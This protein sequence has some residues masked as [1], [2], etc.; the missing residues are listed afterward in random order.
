MLRIFAWNLDANV[1]ALKVALHHLSEGDAVPTITVLTEVPD[2]IN[3]QNHGGNRRM[4]TDYFRRWLAGYMKGAAVTSRWS[5]QAVVRMTSQ[6]VA[7]TRRGHNQSHTAILYAGPRELKFRHA[8]ERSVRAEIPG[9]YPVHVVGLHARSSRDAKERQ[10]STAPFA[11]ASA[12]RKVLEKQRGLRIIAGDFNEQPFDPVLMDA[13]GYYSR[14]TKPRHS[15]VPRCWANLTWQAI[16]WN[17]IGTWWDNKAKTWKWFDQI[18]VDTETAE[19]V[20][21]VRVLETVGNQASFS[22][23]DHAP[24]E[25]ILRVEMEL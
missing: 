17:S 22:L 25:A 18:L 10:E 21:S 24:I 9:F 5:W 11:S 13:G 12:V 8:V 3:L 4:T 6:A 1:E 14:A 7:R 20:S 2:A 23:S 15:G 19:H 16:E